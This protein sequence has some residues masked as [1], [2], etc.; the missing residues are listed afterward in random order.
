MSIHN[1]TLLLV[2]VAITGLAVLLQAMVLLAI[3]LALRK[4]AAK[5]QQQMEDLRNSVMPVVTSTQKLLTTVGPKVEAVAK[6]LAEISGRLRVQSLEMQ[7]TT[8]EFFAHLQKQSS[9]MDAMMTGI[10]DTLDRAGGVL[11]DAINIPIRRV[12]AIAAFAKAALGAL[13]SGPPQPRP[14]HAAADKDLFV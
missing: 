14:T 6:D 7:V 4:T 2:F 1:D 5:M 13:R 12:S 9:R 3:F 11:T 8:S 10:L